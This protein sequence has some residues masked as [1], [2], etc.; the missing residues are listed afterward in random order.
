MGRGA[1]VIGDRGYMD[2]GSRGRML[3]L[4]VLCLKCFNKQIEV[5]CHL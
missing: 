1:G 4:C 3:C 2:R 5:T